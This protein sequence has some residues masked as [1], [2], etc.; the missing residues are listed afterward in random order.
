MTLCTNNYSITRSIHKHLPGAL[1]P[2]FTFERESN[3]GGSGMIH[4]DTEE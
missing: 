3:W 4:I 2:F 1:P